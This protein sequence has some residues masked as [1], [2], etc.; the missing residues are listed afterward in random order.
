MTGKLDYF[1]NW[2][3]TKSRKIGRCLCLAT[4]GQLWGNS[5]ISQRRRISTLLSYDR[6][7]ADRNSRSFFIII[8]KSHRRLL[9]YTGMN[10][11]HTAHYLQYFSC[12]RKRQLISPVFYGDKKISLSMSLIIIGFRHVWVPYALPF[13]KLVPK[14]IFSKYNFPLLDRH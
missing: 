6:L 12:S 7:V 2:Q 5:V 4:L 9:D 14:I 1:V 3:T 13:W 10:F 8:I 11:Y